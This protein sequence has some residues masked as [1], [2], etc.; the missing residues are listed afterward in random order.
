MTTSTRFHLDMTRT[1]YVLMIMA[2]NISVRTTRIIIYRPSRSLV[3]LNVGN[4]GI[5]KCWHCLFL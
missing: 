1:I 5:G 3:E 2:M 4:V